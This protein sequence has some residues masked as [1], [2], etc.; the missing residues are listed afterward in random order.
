MNGGHQTDRAS[1]RRAD[2]SHS[3]RRW[4]NCPHRPLS[5][6][7]SAVP[8]EIRD[9]YFGLGARPTHRAV[10]TL[11]STEIIV[12]AARHLAQE[13]LTSENLLC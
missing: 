13:E 10:F 11:R 12:L 3:I 1:K 7:N 4:A 2:I 6:E 9:H 8:F 5:P